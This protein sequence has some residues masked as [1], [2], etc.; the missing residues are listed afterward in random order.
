[1]SKRKSKTACAVPDGLNSIDGLSLINSKVELHTV[2]GND[3][4][5]FPERWAFDVGNKAISVEILLGC[6]LAT[7]G[8]ELWHTGHNVKQPLGK[9]SCFS[10]LPSLHTEAYETR[11]DA[12]VAAARGVELANPA[13]GERLLEIADRILQHR[14]DGRVSEMQINQQ[15]RDIISFLD[16]NPHDSDRRKFIDGCQAAEALIRARQAFSDKPTQ[17]LLD[18]R[19][20]QLRAGGSQVSSPD[21]RPPAPAVR[22]RLRKEMMTIPVAAIDAGENARTTIDQ[23]F[24]A[25]L[26]E[27]IRT[28]GL[29]EP[30]VVVKA[31]KR[32]SLIAGFQR[33]EAIKSIGDEYVMAVVYDPM[34]EQTAADLHLVENLQRRDL[35]HMDVARWI[36][37]AYDAGFTTA[38]IRQR[39][40]GSEDFI[41]KR[42]ALLRLAKP[43]WPLV[44]SGVLPVK[45][46]ELI[47]RVASHDDQC[48]LAASAIGG[49]YDNRKKEFKARSWDAKGGAVLAGDK[50]RPME[51]LRSDVARAMLSIAAGGWSA[52]DP[53][54]GKPACVGCVDCS[55]TSPALFAELKPQGSDRK[56][57]C[58]NEPC[59][60]V[61]EKAQEKIRDAKRKENEKKLATKVRAAKK[62]GLDVCEGH[63]CGKVANAGE[64][65]E[66]LDGKKYCAKCAKKGTRSK[67]GRQE[68]SPEV[69]RLRAWGKKLHGW[70]E[71]CAKLIRESIDPASP[72]F[73]SHLVACW[74]SGI[75]YAD[76][77]P[78]VG[79]PYTTRWGSAGEPAKVNSLIDEVKS[80]LRIELLDKPGAALAKKLARYRDELTRPPT[81]LGY[82]DHN[83]DAKSV[84]QKID[85]AVKEMGAWCRTFPAIQFPPM[86]QGDV[87]TEKP[88]TDNGDIIDRILT[89]KKAA[90]MAEIAAADLATLESIDAGKLKG[91]WRRAAVAKRIEQLRADQLAAAE[92]AGEIEDDEDLQ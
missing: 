77:M 51:D 25:D 90:A 12:L 71:A 17:D 7:S 22:D 6:E 69:K 57:Y 10:C 63:N 70:A 21:A 72:E 14:G 56:G 2:N 66:V 29:I 31:G 50:V 53:F 36:G 54:A 59:Y 45:H 19:I 26:A 67:D 83:T 9:G 46:A 27:T 68:A 24:I 11:V 74:M 88:A 48:E 49:E 82:L 28:L 47:A 76:D 43:I 32:F 58:L 44:D 3:V 4:F 75:D 55:A 34:D 16:A 1:M 52:E 15:A 81:E 86:P 8:K 35:S 85:E 40:G 87:A 91:D 80:G 84:R 38:E 92:D 60:R 41:T 73:I 39:I 23:V 30:I 62:A 89:G 20:G 33:L 37:L 61:K 65:F 78:N 42:H 18:A 79:M 13:A 5:V 64:T